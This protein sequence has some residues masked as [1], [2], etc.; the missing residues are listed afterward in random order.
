[1]AIFEVQDATGDTYE[2]DAPDE[3]TALKAFQSFKP[4]A[5]QAAQQPAP[6]APAN[7]MGGFAQNVGTDIGGL[8]GGIPKAID[9]VAQVAVGGALNGVNM[10]LPGSMQLGQNPRGQEM[11]QTARQVPQAID[12]AGHLANGMVNNFPGVKQFQGAL[13][14]NLPAWAARPGAFSMSGQGGAQGDAQDEQA[15]LGAMEPINTLPKLGQK[16]YEKPVTSA[17]NISALL[18]GGAGLVGR[19]AALGGK[20]GKLAAALGK[21]SEYT[22]PVNI[23]AKPLKNFNASRNADK[24]IL[25]AAMSQEEVATK[26]NGM[27]DDIRGK[28]VQFPSST[29][30]PFAADIKK[31]FDNIGSEAA[32]AASSLKKALMGKLGP[33]PVPAPYKVGRKTMH[34]QPMPD[35][36]TVPFNDVNEIRQ[37]ASKMSADMKLSDTERKVAGDLKSKIDSYY[38]TIPS[39]NE[40]LVPAREMSR[41]NI[42]A[43]Q[44]GEMERKA[45]WYTSGNES[46]IKNQINAFGKKDGKS[47]TVAEEKAIKNVGKK[48][49]VNSII[50]TT[51]GRL[52]QL[53][54]GGVG[55]SLGGIPGLAGAGAAHLVARKLAER[56]T[57]KALGTA[58]KT[59]LL[60]KDGQRLLGAAKEMTPESL[61]IVKNTLRGNGDINKL[62]SDLSANRK[63]PMKDKVLI[64]ALLIG[65]TGRSSTATQDISP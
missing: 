45:D 36:R 41:R 14:A 58:K 51:G 52:G 24:S 3:G 10:M 17:L 65:Q 27:W 38:E 60:G 20:G 9:G 5:P 29:F 4:Q 21:A 15:F 54:L 13:D 1:M 11:M 37:S 53:I 18:G 22:N 33:M 64:R 46:G 34:P 8:V 59:V 40:K 19:S 57:L 43:K 39:L 61:A 62:L 32:P 35:T 23:I 26:A 50:S 7:S 25:D 49:G 47:L 2:I 55:A 42:M 48:E 28:D 16:M 6:Q 56:S 30:K 63:V 44:L 12:A 31:S